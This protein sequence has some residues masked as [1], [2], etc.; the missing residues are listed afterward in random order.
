MSKFRKYSLHFAPPLKLSV[1]SWAV[2]GNLGLDGSEARVYSI[3][4]N[5]PNVRRLT[6]DRAFY[7]VNW[8]ERVLRS[9]LESV[10]PCEDPLETFVQNG[11]VV[12]GIALKVDDLLS[13]H[14]PH[15]VCFIFAYIFPDAQIFLHFVSS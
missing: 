9:V 3:Q 7:A 12:Y 13:T 1:S 8:M 2:S 4:Q 11:R 10:A 5:D 14:A 15:L 6:E